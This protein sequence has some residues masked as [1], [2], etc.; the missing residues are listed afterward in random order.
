L[1]GDGNTLPDDPR[2]PARPGLVS[3]HPEVAP[4]GSLRAR[5][6][7]GLFRRFVKPR[8]LHRP[9]I[10]ASRAFVA[11]F[12]LPPPF[13]TRVR[14]GELGG[15]P[16]EWVTGREASAETLIYLHGGAYAVC[17]PAT[18]RQVTGAFARRG[19]RVFAPDYRL[20][21][22]H[23]YPA[24]LDDVV[25]AYRALLEAGCAPSSVTVAGE[26]AG[27]GL[28]LA[29]LV[30]LRDAGLPLPAAAALFSP[31]ADLSLAGESLRA[32]EALDAMFHGRH[33]AWVAS[34]YLGGADPRDPH[35]SPVYANLTGLPPLLIH[36]GETELLLDDARRIAA[37]AQ[38]DGLT[39]SFSVWRD[40]VHGWQL[41]PAVLP[42]AR[43]SIDEAA[44]FMRRD[45]GAGG[46][47]PA[48]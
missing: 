8:S 12:V 47:R 39:V 25:A 14:P 43:R 28:A 24:A 41:F 29:L 32:N 13:R 11:R 3:L 36:V 20:A 17:S 7:I 40:V 42:E 6:L 27:G 30:R 38:A 5:L 19:F 9:D 31:W 21:P 44:A 10:V 26:S 23:P 2:P 45:A 4:R 48:A 35:V 22:E 46:A 16:G 1:I 33:A 37:R 15:V 18:H 34:L